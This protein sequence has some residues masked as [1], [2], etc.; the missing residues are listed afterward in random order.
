MV[1]TPHEDK[2]SVYIIGLLAIFLTL[3][4]NYQKLEW[5]IGSE[6]FDIRPIIKMTAML[7]IAY[8][9]MMVIGY[10]EDVVGRMISYVLRGMAPSFLLLSFSLTGYI[11]FIYF[12]IGYYDRI[13]WISSLMI[14][15]CIVAIINEYFIN[16]LQK[17][18]FGCMLKY[19]IK[20]MNVENVFLFLFMASSLILIYPQNR[21][22]TETWFVALLMLFFYFIF[23]IRN[24]YGKS[25][26]RYIGDHYL[27][28]HS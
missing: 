10:S 8:C 5:S 23:Y 12:V 16:K 28:M 7:W 26:Y 17:K 22:L 27:E 6:I 13:F 20:K 18:R 11:L 19:K 14:F 1:L 4:F 15:F 2:R 3:M 25:E 24:H 21:Y 9:F